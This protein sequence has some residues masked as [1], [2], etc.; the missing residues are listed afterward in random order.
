MI[1]LKE[2]AETCGV[3][4]ATVSNILNGKPKVSEAT[5]ARVMEVVK[6]HD[7][8]P[9]YFAQGMRRKKTKTIGIIAEDLKEFSA[10]PIVEAIMAG[11]E[12]ENYRTLLI[13]LRMY[14]KW[15]DTWYKDKEKAESVVLPALRQMQAIKVDGI[16][17]VAGHCREIDYIPKDYPI[18]MLIAYG[19]SADERYSS[20]IIDDLNGGYNMTK[21]LI[22]MGH[23]KIGLIAGRKDNYHTQQ[24]LEGYHKALKEAG[25][26]YNSDIVCYGSWGRESGRKAMELLSEQDITAVFAMNDTM[27]AGAYDYMWE[28]GLEIGKDC[29]MVGYDNKIISEYLRPLLTTNDIQLAELGK[30]AAK[31]MVEELNQK[32]LA[33]AKEESDAEL[34]DADLVGQ[35]D[36]SAVSVPE[37]RIYRIASNMIVRDSVV[38]LEKK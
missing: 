18:P 37:K 20:V 10:T 29:S 25:I 16:I 27:A 24:R 28:K 17:Y 15:Q 3:S 38:K 33:E 7:Y 36:E 19:M 35:P 31:L 12:D 32:E 2:I 6:A 9:N 8:Q 1:T 30:T 11:C 13:N 14:D 4:V 5:R 21:Y 34:S 26:K 22:D 23:K